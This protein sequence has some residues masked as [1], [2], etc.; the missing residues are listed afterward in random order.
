M[1]AL[2][3]DYISQVDTNETN[4]SLAQLAMATIMLSICVAMSLLCLL[5]VFT[6]SRSN[7][8]VRFGRYN[9][10]GA[11]LKRVYHDVY[12]PDDGVMVTIATLAATGVVT[13]AS[14]WFFSRS[15]AVL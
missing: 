14:W 15:A 3:D 9:M 11:S 13:A 2:V 10:L 5:L 12:E 4:E 1:K 6:W 8:P 7:E